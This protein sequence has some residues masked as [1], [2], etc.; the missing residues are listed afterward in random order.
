MVF[1]ATVLALC[2]CSNGG[3][4]GDNGNGGNGGS[5]DAK[6]GADKP[7]EPITLSVF[8]YRGAYVPEDFAKYFADPVK[9][10]FSYITDVKYIQTPD[11][12]KIQEML[13]AGD[14]PDLVITGGRAAIDLVDPGI[15]LD[16]RDLAKKNNLDLNT[17]D[18]QALNIAKLPGAKG[19]LYSLPLWT[20]YYLTFYNKDIFDHFG[21]SYPK[22]NMTWDDF[23]A[24]AI[25]LSREDNGVQYKGM[26]PGNA[27][28]IASSLGLEYFEP[29]TNKVKVTTDGW[30][31]AFDLGKKIYSIEGNS[32]GNANLGN[33]DDNFI[34]DKNVAI[35]P[36]FSSRITKLA[37]PALNNGLNWD[38][39][40]YPS[41]PESKGIGAEADANVLIV[42]STSKHQ[43]DAFQ[44]AKYVTTDADQQLDLARRAATLP[45]VNL[46]QTKDVFG[47][48][49]PLLKEKNINAVFSSKVRAPR[50][51][52]K[53]ETLVQ[54]IVNQTFIKWLA[55]SDDRVT[56]LRQIEEQAN[57]AVEAASK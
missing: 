3:N 44:V 36:G 21:V 56:V 43:D 15:A 18:P 6:A 4:S 39:V 52:N 29:K 16:L 38:M 41:Y 51:F 20:N 31:K 42:S 12:K 1:L 49:F 53:Y 30:A 25:K 9:K 19:E 27:N 47:E 35:L 33:P 2:A 55:T 8:G 45:V 5:S 37:N 24:L 32:P 48:A 7:H 13:T 54:P 17:Y 34:K 22:D 23:T 14:F 57:K 26:W 10:K 50:S 11:T 40:S 46:K 28:L